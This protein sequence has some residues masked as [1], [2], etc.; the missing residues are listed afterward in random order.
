MDKLPGK[1]V[2]RLVQKTNFSHFFILEYSPKHTVIF[3]QKILI[4]KYVK[5]AKYIK[6]GQDFFE[7][8][9]T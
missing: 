4:H 9:E 7:K 6:Y 2:R 3:G 5:Y 1:G 8:T